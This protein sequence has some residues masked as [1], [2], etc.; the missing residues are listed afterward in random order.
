MMIMMNAKDVFL[1]RKKELIE[2]HQT[3]IEKPNSPKMK[4]LTVFLQDILIL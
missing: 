1:K 3:L 4:Y 2:E